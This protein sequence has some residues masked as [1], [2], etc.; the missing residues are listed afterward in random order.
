M[1]RLPAIVLAASLAVLCPLGV[2]GAD[3]LTVIPEK[4]LAAVISRDPAAMERNARRMFEK[5]TGQPMPEGALLG[6]VLRHFGL[7]HSAAARDADG[8]PRQVPPSRPST[9][10]PRWHLSW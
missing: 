3:I 7:H 8:N 6:E 2:A 9:P 10:R 4:S 5:L 1:R